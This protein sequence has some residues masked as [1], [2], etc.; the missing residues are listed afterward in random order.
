MTIERRIDLNADAGEGFDSPE[1]F[2]AV[3]SVSVACGGHVGD[4]SSMRAA[5]ELALASG[6]AIGAHPSYEDRARFGRVETGESAAAIGELARRQISD[7]AEIA[8][9][10]GAPL[11][12]VK[13]HGALYHRVTGDASAARAFVAA[14]SRL[15]DGLAVF[16]FPGSKLLDAA[17]EAGLTVVPEGFAERRYGDDGMLVPRTTA[18][19]HLDDLEAI[20]QAVRLAGERGVGTVCVHSDAPGAAAL[21]TAIR[22]ELEAAS[23]AVKPAVEA[24]R[25][26]ALP[27]LHVVGAAIVEAGRVLLTRRSAHMSMAGKWEFPGGKVEPG[28]EPAAALVREIREELGLEIE[29]EAPIGRGTAIHGGRR[30]V[31]EAYA[32]R[33]RSGELRLHEHEEHGWFTASELGELDWPAADLPILPALAR[34]LAAEP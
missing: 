6:V 33:R 3:S 21:T 31:L 19:F 9:R 7:L 23:F 27:E 1:L 20:E 26:V 14:I 15:D 4:A 30:I 18:D 34:R 29:I 17:R 2:S 25:F 32:A 28:E 5:V 10:A 24:S 11:A 13:P 8:A 12:H 16:G 22:R